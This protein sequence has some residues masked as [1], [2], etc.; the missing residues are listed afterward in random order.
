MAETVVVLTED[1]LQP[2]DARQIAEYYGDLD[3]QFQVLVPADTER[4]VFVDVIDALG[5]L[6]LRRAW[7]DLTEEPDVP[8]ARQ[9]AG[10]ALAT[11]LR[12]FA[13]AGAP[14]DGV[15][16]QDDPL[17][18]LMQAVNSYRAIEVVVVTAPKLLSDALRRD[19]ASRARHELGVPVLHLYTGS[20]IVG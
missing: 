20:S 18:A 3:A 12:R 13:D 11:S 4:N 14:A 19:W 2:S 1:A 17:P 9:E 15:I 5:M 8:E 6:D 16:V 10:E 7:E